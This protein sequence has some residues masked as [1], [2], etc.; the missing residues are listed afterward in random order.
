MRVLGIFLPAIIFGYFN[1][2]VN[3]REVIVVAGNFTLN[4]ELVNIAEY[5][6][7]SGAWSNKYEPVLYLYGESNG[8]I[9]DIAVN[10]SLPYNRLFVVGAFDTVAKTSQVEFCSVGEWDGVVFSKVGEGLC[11]R[12]DSSASMRLQT[13]VLGNDGDLFVGGS[14]ESRVWNGSQFVNVYN[15]AHFRAFTSSWL[16]LVGGSL[17]CNNCIP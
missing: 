13:S 6:I 2:L 12:G 1:F 8:V 10:R 16:P 15:V 4:G 9:W 5:D 11:P 7:A 3:G 17:L 14:F